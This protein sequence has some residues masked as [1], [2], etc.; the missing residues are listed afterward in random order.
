MNLELYVITKNTEIL[1]ALA[2]SI[3]HLNTLQEKKSSATPETI[4]SILGEE[5]AE[6]DFYISQLKNIIALFNKLYTVRRVNTFD[7]QYQN[8]ETKLLEIM[9]DVQEYKTIIE[10]RI[11]MKSR[12][13]DRELQALEKIRQ[14]LNKES[15]ESLIF[16]KVLQRALQK[17]DLLSWSE[18]QRALQPFQE[19]SFSF[20]GNRAVF[21]VL[22]SMRLCA[23]IALFGLIACNDP[24]QQTPVRQQT[25]TVQESR[26]LPQL[27]DLSH[28]NQIQNVLILCAND[29]EKAGVI[30]T[31]KER[32]GRRKKSAQFHIEKR[33]DVSVIDDWAVKDTRG[34]LRRVKVTI[35]SYGQEIP[36]TRGGYQLITMRGHTG[37]MEKLFSEASKYEAT[38][39]TYIF[40]GCEGDQFVQEFMI[41]RRAIIADREVGE[42]AN[43]TYLLT[44]I[45][46]RMG[47]QS[48]WAS[49]SRDI[50]GLSQRATSQTFFPG[51]SL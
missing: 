36:T 14:A 3:K 24:E 39:T 5:K 37:D 35:V 29:S 9:R 51:D 43:N 49:L 18:V 31:L 30:Q 26:A 8:L 17:E 45:I 32:N 13:P 27:E 20:F 19:G 1:R 23:V 16:Q 6:L 11:Q 50:R 22:P 25:T 33:G 42:A 34:N 7:A 4:F 28:F 48:S 44:L 40:G 12:N 38:Y 41:P 15:V 21:S 10:L 2:S 46:D 47:Q